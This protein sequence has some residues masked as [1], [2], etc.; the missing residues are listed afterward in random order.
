MKYSVIKRKNKLKEI[1][2]GEWIR[3]LCRLEGQNTFTR[4][5]KIPCND[6]IYLSLNNKAK[7]TSIEIR[8]YQKNVKGNDSVDYTDEAYLKQRRHLNPMVFK[9]LNYSIRKNSFTI[10]IL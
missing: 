5:R 6:L 1:I 3:S 4:N 2:E 8:D 9:K 10:L 7:T